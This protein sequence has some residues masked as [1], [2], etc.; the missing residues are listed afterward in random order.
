LPVE[1]ARSK[2]YLAAERIEWKGKFYRSD[3]ARS[4]DPVEVSV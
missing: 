2:A 3:I 4:E 1:I